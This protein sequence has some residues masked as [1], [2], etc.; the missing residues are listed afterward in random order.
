M[1][2]MFGGIFAAVSTSK[3]AYQLAPTTI[4]PGL[5]SDPPRGAFRVPLFRD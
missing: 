2:S 4:Q 5:N 1:V 3:L